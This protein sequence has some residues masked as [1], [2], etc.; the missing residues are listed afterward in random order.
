MPLD[1]CVHVVNTDIMSISID[2]IC[3]LRV[4]MREGL[5]RRVKA[6]TALLGKTTEEWVIEILSAELD[7]V[8]EEGA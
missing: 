8:K 2:T 4:R 7:R 5:R 1:N 6:R 3:F